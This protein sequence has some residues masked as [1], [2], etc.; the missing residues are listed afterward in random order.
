M[1]PNNNKRKKLV[2]SQDRIKYTIIIL[3]SLLYECMNENQ[4]FDSRYELPGL[5]W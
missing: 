4:L 1:L 3:S 5:R 2:S